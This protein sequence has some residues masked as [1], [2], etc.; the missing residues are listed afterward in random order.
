L[1]VKII[2]T[3]QESI[4]TQTIY[5]GETDD[6]KKPISSGLEIKEHLKTALKS[7]EKLFVAIIAA[8]QASI[9]TKT[10]YIG[11]TDDDGDFTGEYMRIKLRN[12]HDL[13]SLIKG[14]YGLFHLSSPDEILRSFD[15]IKDG[16]KYQLYKSF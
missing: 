4:A 13:K 3:I 1:F 6:D 5:I 2:P 11:V 14:T 16:E 8:T 9:T 12:D 7:L 10:T 15:D